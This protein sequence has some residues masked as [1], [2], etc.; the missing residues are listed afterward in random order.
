MDTRNQTRLVSYYLKSEDVMGL[1]ATKS[2]STMEG[3]NSRL[4]AVEWKCM[5]GKIAGLY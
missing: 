5:E 4:K 3:L 2:Y 1:I